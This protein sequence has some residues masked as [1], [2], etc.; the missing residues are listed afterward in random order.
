VAAIGKHMGPGVD[1]G[2]TI[3]NYRQGAARGPDHRYEPAREP[4]ITKRT[5]FGAPDMKRATTAHM[6]RNNGT[7]RHHIGRMRRLCY[8]F[9]K[10]PAHHVAAVALCYAHY[11][12]CW[13]PRTLRE[14]PAMAAGVTDHIW[15]LAEF[16]DAVLS[17]EPCGLPA[18]KPLAPR[19]PEGPARELPNGR[20]FLRLVPP[21]SDPSGSSGPAAPSPGPA[22]PAVPAPVAATLSG[23]PAP[24]AAP[25]GLSRAHAPTHAGSVPS[26]APDALPG[27]LD[28]LS[29]RAPPPQA[30]PPPREPMRHL[31]PGEL[32]LFGLDLE[33][34]PP[35]K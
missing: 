9:S 12:L 32:S 31:S 18:R 33:P 25:A 16:M 28:L 11:N 19:T 35:K 23:S 27:Q 10:S 24:V 13:I 7:M 29:Y 26:T 2:Q 6:E 20:G 1:Y 8:A 14:T 22:A 5:V 30:P 34:E 17:A 4:F 15:E 21:G 3:K